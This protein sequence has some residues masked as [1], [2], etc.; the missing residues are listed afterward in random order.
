MELKNRQTSILRSLLRSGEGMTIRNLMDGYAI[1]RRTLYYDVKKINDWLAEDH[2]GEIWISEQS[3]K[4]HVTDHKR[5]EKRMSQRENYFFSV[6]ERHSMEIIYI[7]LYHEAV[8]VQK[9]EDYFDV[10]RNTILTDIKEIRKKLE[11]NA[12]SLDTSVKSGYVIRGEEATIRKMLGIQIRQL[13]N[14]EGRAAVK[15]LFQRSL[16]ILT[17]NDIDF[18][19]LCNSVIYQYEIDTKGECIL[20]NVGYE[21]LRIQMALIR[22]MKGYENCMSDEEK[23]ILMNTLSYRSLEIS[24]EKLKIHNIII[25]ASEIYY[26]TSLLMG[27][28]TVDFLSQ[29]WEDSYIEKICVQLI[30]NFERIGCLFFAD[31]EH[32][33]KQLMHHVRPLY[34]RLKYAVSANNPMVRDIKRMYPMVFDITERAFEELDSAFPE[35]VSDEELAYICVYMASNLNEKMIELSN[36][37]SEKGILIIGAENMATATM[38]KEQLQQLLGITFKYSV[39]S[40]TKIRE[41]MLEE[42]I[43]VV[44]VGELKNEINCDYLVKTDPVLTETDQR[45][46]IDVLKGNQAIARYDRRINDIISIVNRNTSGYLENSNLYFELF[47]YFRGN[48]S[49]GSKEAPADIFKDKIKKEE[50]VFLPHH[51]SW[52]GA[53]LTGGRYLQPGEG[54]LCGRLGNLMARGKMHTYRMHRKVMLVHCP[55]QGDEEGKVDVVIMV[56]GSG[57]EC[58]DGKKAYIIVCLSTIDNYAH[59]GLLRTIYRYFETEDHVEGILNCYEEEKE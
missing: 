49:G 7:A 44:V 20:S 45:R 19:E 28:Q 57:I 21:S 29:D 15:Q 51:T 41:W 37:S 17:E 12:L 46:I 58:P 26:I 13:L 10:S 48:D 24:A 5:L 16:K 38:V 4:V 31:R 39:T 22:S 33:Q 6:A 32:L 3:V 42:Y 54:S 34:Y 53:V 43:L 47:R 56:S 8:T 23:Y 14:T 36:E 35:E 50:F 18:Y 40:S 59:W 9:L 2:L 55:M 30:V 25:P 52:E 11:K 1:A 27:I